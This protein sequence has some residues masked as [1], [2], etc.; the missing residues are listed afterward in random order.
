MD[1]LIKAW[2]LLVA[3]SAITTALATFSG[4]WGVGFV[5]VILILSGWKARIILNNYLGLDVS[6]FW[7]RGFNAFIGMFLLLVLG[8]YFLPTAL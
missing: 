2:I 1:R 3:L 5:A 4:D 8:L 6:G 7:R